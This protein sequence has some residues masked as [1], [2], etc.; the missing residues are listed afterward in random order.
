MTCERARVRRRP[1]SRRARAGSPAAAASTAAPCRRLPAVLVALAVLVGGGYF[2]FSYG[3]TAIK[4]KL[5]PPPDYSG[6]GTGK[7]LVE[8]HDGDSATDIAATLKAKG[9]VKSQQA[10]NDAARKDPKSTGIQ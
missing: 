5:Q 3:L 9:V 4:E 7:V 1:G 6:T 10:F 2:A 8:V